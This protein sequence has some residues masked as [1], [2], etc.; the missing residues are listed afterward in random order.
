[1]SDF[2]TKAN[3]YLQT[4]AP[5]DL[6]RTGDTAR[7]GVVLRHT[8]EAARRASHWYAPIIP[9][10]AAEASRRLCATPIETGPPLF[11]RHSC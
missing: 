3:R 10:A 11:P 6:A 9:R 7:L 5:W 4:T 8:L 1:M 2:V